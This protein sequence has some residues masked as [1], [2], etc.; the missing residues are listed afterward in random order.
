MKNAG[1][2]MMKKSQRN[3]YDDTRTKLLTLGYNFGYVISDGWVKELYC[4]QSALMLEQ[5]VMQITDFLNSTN[6]MD[7]NFTVTCD[8]NREEVYVKIKFDS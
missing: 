6:T 8:K 3:W 1:E 5:T 4:F 2:T 7:L